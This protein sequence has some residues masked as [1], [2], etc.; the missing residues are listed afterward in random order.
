MRI[1]PCRKE[2]IAP[3]LTVMDAFLHEQVAHEPSWTPSP[4][5][6]G[7]CRDF[8]ERVVDSPNYFID[9]LTDDGAIAGFVMYGYHEEPMFKLSRHGYLA[10]LYVAPAQRRR[11]A[12]RALAEFALNHLR[13]CDVHYVQLNVLQANESA[14]A[15]WR[16][17]GF[18]DQMLRMKLDLRDLAADLRDADHGN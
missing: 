10:D 16:A 8:L 18:Q 1:D 17:V 9:L 11:G 2:D 6:S 7:V 3:L 13:K 5:W 15:F 14:V 12:G 4:A